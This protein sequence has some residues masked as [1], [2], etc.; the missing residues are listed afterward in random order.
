[1]LRQKKFSST[2]FLCIWFFVFILSSIQ[3]SAYQQDNTKVNATNNITDHVTS[4]LAPTESNKKLAYPE[5][6]ER[7]RQAVELRLKWRLSEAE[8]LWNEIL[9]YDESN[10]EAL[11]SLAEIER[12]KLNYLKSLQ[13]LK[14]AKELPPEFS[15]NPA[16]L[17][18]AYGSLYLALEE[19]DKAEEYFSNARKIK[20]N[21]YGAI[22]GQA[23]VALLKRNYSQAEQLLNALLADEPNRLEARVLLARVYLEQ[24]RNQ[25]AAQEAQKVLDVDKYNVEAMTALCAVRVAEKKPEAVRKLA[26]SVLELNPYN[27]GVRRLLSQYLNSKK[28]F[29]IRLS[30]EGQVIITNAD[31]LKEAG[32]YEEAASLYKKVSLMES[33]SLRA[34]LGLGAC[35]ILLGNYTS[36]IDSAEKALLLDPESALAHLQLSLAHNGLHERARIQAGATDWRKNY[37]TKDNKV[38]DSVAE[39]FVNYNNFSKSEQKVIEEAVRPLAHYLAELK[40]KGAK[41]YLLAVDKKLS[42]VIGYESLDNRMTFDGRYYASV[43]GVGGLVTVSGV[44]YLEVAMRGGF[45]T[46]AHEFAHQV[47][48]SVLPTEVNERIKKLYQKAVKEGNVLDYYAASNEWEYFAQGY[49]AYVSNFK[50]PSAGVTAR[51]TRRELAEL[52]PD[53]YNLIEELAGVNKTQIPLVE[54]ND[55]KIDVKKSLI[56]KVE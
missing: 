14:R 12:T 38:P 24:N 25:L 40:R 45:N 22:L 46:I 54:N 3:V 43:R 7:T 10:A 47:H 51:H 15:L 23:G 34:L 16:Q 18:T 32:K 41:H 56:Y 31:N 53:L 9:K 48:T 44:E 50:R 29:L 30:A 13:Y 5:L 21:Y 1:M 2:S 33:R 20:D 19:A 26:K 36:A 39:V 17:L 37:Q 55:N 42:D 52:D 27:S 6:A 11:I 4:V 28:I 35:D 49:E 8:S